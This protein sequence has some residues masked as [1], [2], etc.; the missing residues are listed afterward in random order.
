MK[1][2]IIGIDKKQRKIVTENTYGA[3]EVSDLNELD[4]LLTADSLENYT[5]VYIANDNS[6]KDKAYATFEKKLDDI[7]EFP[8]CVTSITTLPLDTD[9]KKQATALNERYVL[10][11]ATVKMLRECAEYEIIKIEKDNEKEEIIVSHALDNGASKEMRYLLDR[12]V[13]TLLNPAQYRDFALLTQQL[14]CAKE[15]EK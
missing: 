1:Y 4:V 13:D 10:H 9:L 15:L 6:T 8:L 3:T 11:N 5:L 14:L 12:F 7:K 2:L